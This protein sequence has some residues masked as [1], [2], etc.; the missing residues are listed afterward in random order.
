MIGFL[1][2][3][4]P[5]FV[6]FCVSVSSVFLCCLSVCGVFLFVRQSACGVRR[7]GWCSVLCCSGCL[8]VLSVCGVCL[9][10]RKGCVWGRSVGLGG[11]RISKKSMYVV[12]VC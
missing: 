12:W 4:L 6:F 5:I 7:G 10:V 2:C 8:A 3:V 1:P 9:S 11:R